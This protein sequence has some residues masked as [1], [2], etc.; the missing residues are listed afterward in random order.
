M[1]TAPHRASEL[2]CD[3]S[4]IISRIAGLII[5]IS[6]QP[7]KKRGSKSAGKRRGSKNKIVPLDAPVDFEPHNDIYQAHGLRV[8]VR[9]TWCMQ[10]IVTAVGNQL[11]CADSARGCANRPFIS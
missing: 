4:M 3:Y 8:R 9:A 11:K 5:V 7:P 6:A 10:P 1:P 2:K